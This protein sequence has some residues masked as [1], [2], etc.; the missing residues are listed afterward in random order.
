MPNSSTPCR[1][2]SWCNRSVDS[3]I[4]GTRFRTEAGTFFVNG[5]TVSEVIWQERLRGAREL[6]RAVAEIYE[7]YPA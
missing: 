6:Q 3:V 4:A 1:D 7:M 5:R 2:W